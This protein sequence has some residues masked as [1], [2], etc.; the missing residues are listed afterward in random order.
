[1]TVFIWL[2]D[3]RDI[4][5]NRIPDNTDAFH[6]KTYEETVHWLAL[7]I[8]NQVKAIID[9]DHDLGRDKDG[10]DVAKW[11]VESNYPHFSFKIHSMNP[12]GA[13]NIRHL[14][15]HYGYQEL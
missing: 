10:Y 12:V 8:T 14:L 1:M 15:S 11:I 6:C 5:W 13:A 9:F 3:E 4:N 7:C 2:D